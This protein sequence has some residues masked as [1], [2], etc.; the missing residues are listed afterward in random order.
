MPPSKNKK[1]QPQQ[2][3]APLSQRIEP[4]EIVHEMRQ[5]Y[6]DY[7]MSVIVARALP[8][9]RDG[10]KP[11]QRRIL[12]AM[13][14]IGLHN[15][16]KFRKS[17]T[18]VGEVLG[19]F[20]P[21]G[22]ASVYDALARMTQ[23]FSLRYPLVAGQGNFG[24]I[25]GD[26]PA[27]M[28]YTEAKLS[29]LAD[30]ILADIE[31]NTVDFQDNYDGSVQEPTVL[32]TRLPQLLLNGSVGIAVGMAT[33]IPP[34]NVSELLS[35]LELLIDNPK[36]GVEDL[37]GV[38]KGPDFPTG[39]YIYNKKDIVAAYATGKGPI[40]MRGKA[41]IIE[42]GKKNQILI[43][44]IP[45]Q[46]NKAQLIETVANLIHEKRLEGIKDLRDESDREGMRIVVDLKQDA[47][48]QK[49]LNALYKFTDLQKTF[50]VNLLA[51]TDGIQPQVLSL[52][53]LLEQFL[54]HRKTVIR[55]RT[56]FDLA[57]AK[58]RAHILE[59]LSKALDHIDAIIKL[60]KSSPDKD[61]A[62][63]GLMKKFKFSTLQADAIL[64]MKLQT[65]AG[66]ERKKIE[67]ELKEKR[68]FIK[69]CEEILASEKKILGVVRKEFEELKEKYGDDRRTKVVAGAIG[70]FSEEDLT[71]AEEAIVIL[72]KGG[73]IKRLSPDTWKVQHR[74]GKGVIGVETKEEDVVDKFLTVNTHD[75]LLF[76]T[77]KGRVFATRAF[78]VPEGSR[79]SR[80]KALVNL[81]NLGPEEMVSA[82]IPLKEKPGKNEQ[83]QKFLVMATQ[84]GIIKK[85][86]VTEFSNIRSNGLISI[87]LGKGDL[88]NWV[89]LSGGNDEI[90]F[91]TSKGQA[92][93][94][95]EK[96][97]RPMGRA[98]RGV[99]GVRLRS[100]DIVVSMDVLTAEEVKNQELLVVSENGFGKR[101]EIKSYKRQRRGG[102]GIKTAN[103]STKTGT[104]IA[105]SILKGNEEECIA[106]SRKGQVI[107]TSLKAISVQG[108]ATQGVRLMRMKEGDRVASITCL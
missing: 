84:N 31:K 56:E 16:A 53:S 99:T 107:R 17:A 58:E 24:S 103:V 74:G 43:T 90:V 23:D 71:P 20:H 7:A 61:S 5:S 38:I 87:T 44:E 45:Y 6:L 108:R 29:L 27:A 59:G 100:G 54:E 82:A 11:V 30:D 42:N 21:H 57:R 13:H 25:D 22:D 40:V 88:L 36:A 86:P 12:Y 63:D 64:E 106:I 72:T 48:P 85:T 102:V 65:L 14:K 98:A 46:V 104:L 96:D 39:G 52:K 93:R 62:H 35:G 79:T 94:F 19:K 89:H 3:Q 32:P 92:I 101:T 69:E 1:D 2:P 67:D 49:V 26:A 70:E 15:S 41:E 47:F 33:N 51:L 91:V 8:D 80:G 83:Q 37:V 77:N 34:H 95:S 76:F 10:L 4:Q 68:A 18:V 73:Y 28:R 50:H 78:E 75:H 66:L 60:I 97:V 55:R 105:A 9:A 81:L